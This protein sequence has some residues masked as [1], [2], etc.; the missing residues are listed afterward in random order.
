MATPAA[1]YCN[2]GVGAGK[3]NYDLSYSPSDGAGVS[4]I[5]CATL[6][7]QTDITSPQNILYTNA[8]DGM[9]MLRADV[10]TDPIATDGY[11]RT[12]CRELALDGTTLRSFD[13]TT[14]EHWV[15]IVFKVTH[16]PVEKPSVVVCQMHD[17]NGDILE[18]AVQPVTG[19]N[20]TTNPKVELVCRVDSTGT[21]SSS[22]G[23]PKLVAD[24]QYNTVY[25]AK[26][27]VGAIAPGSVT[28]WAAYIGDMV[29]PKLKSWDAGVPAMWATGSANYFKFGCYLQTKST[30][31][32]TGGL[33]TDVNEYGE[34][35]HRDTQTFHNGET[36]PAVLTFGTQTF[37]TISNVRWGTQ[38]HGRQSAAT[39]ATGFTLTPG[40]PASLVNGDLI[41]CI[42]RASRGPNSTS[43]TYTSGA[44]LPTSPSSPN[45]TGWTKL[46]STKSPATASVEGA[47]PGGPYLE[48]HNVRWQLFAKKWVN[49]DLA[50]SVVYPATNTN[51]DTMSCVVGAISGSK[52]TTDLSSFLDQPPS[53]LDLTN[54]ADNNNTVTGISYGATPSTTLLGPTAALPANAAPGSLVIA[55]VFHETNSTTGAVAVVTGGGDALTWSEGVEG[56]TT[57]VSPTA[58]TSD[59]GEDEQAW[60]V[61]W[62]IVSG[63]GASSAVG[64]KT[65]AS[66]LAA[67][68]NKPNASVSTG[69]CG[70][71]VAFSIA[72]AKR[73]GRRRVS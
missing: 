18:V 62:A 41:F 30:G 32:G 55:C 59:S 19:Y 5:T 14:G 66:T 40:L 57:T 3:N 38:A 70:W 71:G 9:F 60:A 4:T 27:R 22:S 31:N 51:T 34:V 65:A 35:G 13:R 73:V 39:N 72:P 16:L 54:P 23:L 69:G 10:D 42:V 1:T 50:P 36:A 68:A 47:Y 28:G 12:E 25:V 8:A 48:A 45:I 44:P 33:E 43:T 46:I 63:S 20:K 49:G 6:A 11:P 2:V 17:E 29:T 53:G 58:G 7:T 26:I 64:A 52:Y 15:K 37:D 24:F 56:S 61:D 67:D 21:G